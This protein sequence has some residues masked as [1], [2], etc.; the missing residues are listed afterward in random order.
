MN[1]YRVL[2]FFDKRVREITV[3]QVGHRSKV[4]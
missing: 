3:Y 1:D 4:Y 2:Y